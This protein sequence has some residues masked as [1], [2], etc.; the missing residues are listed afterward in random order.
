ME[1][2]PD[3]IERLTAIADELDA[4]ADAHSAA[5]E[6]RTIAEQLNAQRNPQ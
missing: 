2:S 1:A 5:R 6:L 4:G 3:P